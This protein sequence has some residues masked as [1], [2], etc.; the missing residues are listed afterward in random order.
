[1]QNKGLFYTDK[2]IETSVS[3]VE[4]EM[5]QKSDRALIMKIIVTAK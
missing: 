1:L 3:F 5:S 4:N 2:S